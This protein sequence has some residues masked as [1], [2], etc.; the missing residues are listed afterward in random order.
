MSASVPERVDLGQPNLHRRRP[1]RREQ[2]V[3]INL[4]MPVEVRKCRRTHRANLATV[5]RA[6]HLG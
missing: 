4:C 5:A 6:R 1:D 2:R 3:D